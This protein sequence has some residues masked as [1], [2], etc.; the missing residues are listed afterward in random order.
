MTRTQFIA[1]VEDILD[2]PRGTLRDS[3]SRDTIGDWSS[4]KDVHILAVI[5]REF[6]L[7]PT[8]E[9][10]E[11]ETVGDLLSILEANGA[12]LRAAVS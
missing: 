12:F 5:S 9:L 1:T 7:Q 3:D 8:S 11:A 6:G 4:I 2:V 10:I